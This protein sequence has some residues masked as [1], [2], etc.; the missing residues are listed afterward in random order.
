MIAN[1]EIDQHINFRIIITKMLHS[2]WFLCWNFF[3]S[4]FFLQIKICFLFHKKFSAKKL[5]FLLKNSILAIRL[6]ISFFTTVKPLSQNL[7]LKIDK[8][9]FENSI[10]SV[11]Q[12]D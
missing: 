5:F 7:S 1:S 8:T 11:H 3:F 9:H 4:I 6:T 10:F 12:L 2:M